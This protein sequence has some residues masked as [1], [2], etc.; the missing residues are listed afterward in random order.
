MDLKS[1]YFLKESL[2]E[3]AIRGTDRLGDDYALKR[4][5]E[6]FAHD[7]GQAPLMRLI[8]NEAR[9]LLTAGP[10]ERN[11]RLLDVLGLVLS[12]E[13]AYG[14]ADVPGELTPTDAGTGKYIHASYSQ[15]QPV[16]AALG[17][18]GSG[19]ISVLEEYWEKRPAYFEDLRVMPHLV[20]A[21]GDTHEELEE[22]VSAILTAQ[23][24]RAVPFLKDGFCPDGKRE[25]E[26]R[27]YW[28][29]RLAGAEENE[30]YLKVLPQSVR[31]VREAVIAALGISQ[32]NAPLLLKLYQSETGKARD[33]ALRALARMEDADSRALWVE[34]LEVRPD[35][36]PCLEGV[37]SVLAADMAAQELRDTYSEA[38][39]RGK[40]GFNQAELLTLAH[41]VYAAYGKYSDT[42]RETW[43]WCAEQM[44]AFDKIHPDRSVHQWDL[45][46]AEM[47]EKCML[48]T[49]LWNPSEN[50]CALAQEL[51]KR[52]PA[53]FLGAAVLAEI[54][55]HPADAYSRYGKFIVKNSIF[56][57]EN[58]A[59]HENRVQIMRALAAVRLTEEDGRHIPFTRKDMLTGAPAPMMYR[60]REFDPRW[61]DALGSPKVNQDGAVFDLQSAWSMNKM[62]FKLEWIS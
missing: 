54:L 7:V 3:S 31:E 39:A 49:V 50:V 33:S 38:L 46:A 44:E 35:C 32:E 8:Y 53:W 14:S 24:K 55:T 62:M 45:S 27:V 43:L 56:H 48:E 22:L 26:R 58:A 1:L 34:Q 20:G 40:E 29:A 19:R 30:W 25:M 2:E 61:A 59:E 17:G 60:M 51:G 5:V 42:L 4:A 36:P 41:A 13:R 21:L 52:Y 23:G 47:L 57:K 37:D 11:A 18:S 9:A 12:A 6:L 16:I 28:I 10:D 15:L